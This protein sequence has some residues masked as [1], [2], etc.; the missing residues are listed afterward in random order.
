MMTYETRALDTDLLEAPPGHVITGVRL[1][2]LGGHVNLEVQITPIRFSSGKLVTDRST[3][4]A[5]DNTPASANPRTQADIYMPDIPTMAHNSQ[6]ISTHNKYIE[7]DAT[8]PHKD[9]R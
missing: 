9:V 8:S 7:F 3:W 6:I 5:N 4:I 2:N 1:R